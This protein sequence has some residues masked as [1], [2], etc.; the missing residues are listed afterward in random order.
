MSVFNVESSNNQA[1]HDC[2]VEPR[3]MECLEKIFSQNG[4]GNRDI[5]QEPAHQQ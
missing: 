5:K 1:R 2:A 4:Y 3:N